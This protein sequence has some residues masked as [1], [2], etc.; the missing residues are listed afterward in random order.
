MDANEDF[1]RTAALL[2]ALDLYE[3]RYET[4]AAFVE[5]IAPALALSL[6]IGV[7][8]PMPYDGGDDATEG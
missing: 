6:P 4:D 3:R 5:V 8:P 2:G 1:A 7:L